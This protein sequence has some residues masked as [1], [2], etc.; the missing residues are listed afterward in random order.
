[1]IENARIRSLNDDAPDSSG[2][3]VLYWMQNSQRAY[4]NHAL[5]HAIRL[6]NDANQPTV[7]G[8]GLM[9]DYPEA[10]ERHFAFML[11][12]LR[13]VAE[14]LSERRIKLVVKRGD[15]AEVALGLA[16]SASSVV[17]DRGYLRHQRRWR[18]RVARE[19]GRRVVQVE[20]DV[21]VPVDCASDRA[22]NAARTLRPKLRR[23]WDDF[24]GDLR[25]TEPVKSS[26]GLAVKGDVDPR[27]P[28]SVLESLDIDRSVKRV[29]RFRG[30][31]REARRLL[32]GFLKSNLAGY[33]DARND[34]SDPQC[35]NLSPYLHFGQISPV[36]IARKTLAGKAGSGKDREA[37]LE[38]LIVRRELAINF[39]VHER[40]YDSYGSLPA[41]ARKTLDEHRDDPRPHRYTRSELE[42]ADTH[43]RY[44]NAATQE[45]LKTGYMHNYMRMYW[46]K[47]IIEWT[48]TPEYAYSTALYL[49]NKYFL[50]G[51]D[52]NSYANVAWLFGLARTRCVRQGALH[53]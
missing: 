10:N 20:S 8:F 15:P 37:F 7:V 14:R 44:W 47:K 33:Q 6:A 50:D 19:A 13:E 29:A 53:E 3:Y 18:E 21:V 34:P 9:A 36:E 5:E 22:E 39:V 23:Q 28:E 42:R 31:T 11:D 12:G 46:G 2:R 26:L 27:R 32:A 4:F 30:G 52:A 25:Q 1:M 43:D 24:L 35:S 40:R 17:C 48:N 45:M 41:W 16:R 38:E 51:R 49:N